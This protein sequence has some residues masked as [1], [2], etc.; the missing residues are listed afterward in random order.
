M[1]LEEKCDPL[2]PKWP[3]LTYHVW[4]TDCCLETCKRRREL[5]THSAA[6]PYQ[7][8][9]VTPFLTSTHFFFHN[10]IFCFHDLKKINLLFCILKYCRGTVKMR[11]YNLA[12]GILCSSSTTLPLF[13]KLSFPI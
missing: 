8:L 12:K 9:H 13:L 4:S 1:I 2:I 6:K 7:I 10:N 11:K 3:K 5:L